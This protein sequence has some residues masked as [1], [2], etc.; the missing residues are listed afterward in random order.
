MRA[1]MLAAILFLAASSAS[2]ID[3]SQPYGGYA[4]VWAP[5]RYA[6][7]PPVYYYAPRVYSAPGYYYGGG[8]GPNTRAWADSQIESELRQIRWALEDN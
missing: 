5:P 3:Y 4:T 8:F 7:A 2:A 6:Y 1:I